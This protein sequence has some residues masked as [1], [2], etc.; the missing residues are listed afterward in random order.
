MTS[1]SGDHVCKRGHRVRAS[2]YVWVLSLRTS[3]GVPHI[4]TLDRHFLFPEFITSVDTFV[5]NVGGD[6]WIESPNRGATT[7]RIA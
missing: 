3:V 2:I 5:T 4:D 6:Q 7:I 1:G